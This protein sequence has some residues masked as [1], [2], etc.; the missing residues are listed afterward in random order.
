M[1]RPRKRDRHLPACVYLRHGAYYYVKAG[2]WTRLGPADDLKGALAEYARLTQS[3][4]RHGMAQLIDE[5]MPHLVRGKAPATVKLY[6]LTADKLRYAFAD[7]EPQDVQPRHVAEL[8]EGMAA[9]PA[10]A[11]RCASVLRMVFARALKMQLVD[12]NPVVGVERHRTQRR[13][14]RI[15]LD[16][17]E[18]ILQ[19]ASPRLRVVMR[20]CAITGQRISDI[21][22]LKREDLLDVGIHFRQRKTGAELVVAWTTELKA[23]VELA[24]AAHGRVASMYVVKGRGPLPLAYQPVWRD[25]QRACEAAGV[26]EATIHDLRAMA[27]S[28]AKRQGLDPQALL[29]HTTERMTLTYLRDRDVP[30]VQPPAIRKSAG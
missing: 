15:T 13:K 20:L 23:A 25:W 17:Y 24:K 4:P 7:F 14:R 22:A 9:T 10:M 1:N 30:I 21:L 28:E 18:A 3:G 8:L 19:H 16:E 11:N 5:A 29:G 27:G 26:I 6:R 2:K 12:A